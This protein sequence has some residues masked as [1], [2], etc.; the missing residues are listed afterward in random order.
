M[1][2]YLECLRC[3]EEITS[4]YQFQ[5][6]GYIKLMNLPQ[7]YICQYF[8]E[9]YWYIATVFLHNTAYVRRLSNVPVLFILGSS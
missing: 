5:W 6:G 8:F 9:H 7:H 3:I 4:G 1:M 2:L